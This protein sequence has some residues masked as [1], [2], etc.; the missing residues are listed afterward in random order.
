L[1]G[2]DTN[3][4]VRYLTED[5][6]AQVRRV[7]AVVTQAL[8]DG[9]TLHVDDV[10]LCEVV[11][12]LRAGYRFGKVAIVNALD[13]IVATALFSF[14]DRDLLRRA[15]DAY[16]SGSG[17]FADYIIGFRNA[18]AGCAHTVTLDGG[19]RGEPAFV[20]L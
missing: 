14:D 19:L 13:R 18:R 7:D 17:D 8:A 12:V 11:W 16:R 9:I 1:I 10:V 3:V 4:L 20:L 5:D 6:P 15:I 2:I